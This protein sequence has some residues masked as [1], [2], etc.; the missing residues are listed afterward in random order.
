MKKE[1]YIL[2][3][4]F[5]STLNSSLFAQKSKYL[6]DG[7]SWELAQQRK[8]SIKELSYCIF[9][10]IPENKKQ[11]VEGEEIIN[12]ELK[13]RQDII[14]DFREDIDKIHSVQV[15]HFASAE[16]TKTWNECKWTF[17][18]EHIIIPK[19]HTKKGKNSI[20]IIFTAGNQSLNRR[21]DYMYTLFV[22]DRARTA[23][24][25]FEQP[26]MKAHFKLTLQIPEKWEAVSN[27]QKLG[28]NDDTSLFTI[29]KDKPGYKIVNFDNSEPL[30]TY[31]FAFAAGDFKYQYFSDYGLG[32]YYRETDPK[33]VAQLPQ[34]AEQVKFALDWQ[35]D[36]TGMKYPFKKYDF[37]ILPGFQYG[38]M[39]HTGATFYNDNRI[40][41]P[42]NPTPDEEL[43]RTELIAHETSHMWFGDA[44]TMNWFDDVWTKE[45]FANYFAAEITT[46]QFPYL[47][48]DLNWLKTYTATAIKQDRT[49]GRT[50]IRQPLDNMRYA[51][52]IYN[53]IIYNKA[54]VMMREMVKIM[55]SEAYKRGIRKYLEKYKYD[56]AT[57][58][59]L[60][61]ILDD[62]TPED[63][64]AFSKKWVDTANYPHYMAASYRDKRIGREYGFYE[65][66]PE[67]CRQLMRYWN[68]ETDGTHRQAL[69]MT[70]EEN[71]LA[72]K[73][74]DETWMNELLNSLKKMDD[75]LTASTLVSYMYEPIRFLLNEGKD[76]DRK[77]WKLAN[78]HHMP[79]V[80]TSLLRLLIKTARTPEVVDSLYSIW[81]NNNTPL[82]SLTD[83]MTLSYE[84]AIRMPKKAN[85]IITVQRARIS[86][87]D[88]LRNFNYVS[89]AVSPSA[90]ARDTLFDSLRKAENRRIEPWTLS[91]LYYLNHPLR[92][93]QSVHYIRP[94]LEMLPEIQ[95]TGDIFFPANWCEYLLAGHRCK[96]A[97]EEVV[98]FLN[99][100]THLLPLLKNKILEAEYFL[101]RANTTEKEEYVKKKFND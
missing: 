88:R 79:E 54:P 73:F 4:I 95:R 11:N 13:S 90:E 30:S 66:S 40:F 45:V 97:H 5:A 9:F 74:D 19:R 23:F 65:L 28:D 91:V 46:P 56:N 77:V 41:L 3:I 59:D 94:A 47:N 92:D 8:Q 64:R 31:L 96:A 86:D 25:C 21:E 83:F 15:A 62:E 49:E 99:D 50:S 81:T 38:G 16:D 100:N 71:Y 84:L 80:R 55:G 75:P 76:Y 20:K 98:S 1:L 48:H 37:V 87:P 58:D 72:K 67:Q 43:N 36:F 2:L 33:R 89:R 26:N 7:V 34:I 101:Q 42:D 70:L 24:P 85:D 69:L 10:S 18:N 82:L 93:E 39:E 35:E 22:P 53:N 61:S 14:I 12:F 29:K 27:T 68:V 63:L 6:V 52:L 78:T 51:G 60:I 44:V 32:V 17:Q 57:W